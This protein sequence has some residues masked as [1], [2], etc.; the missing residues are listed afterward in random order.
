MLR[1]FILF[2]YG[3]RVSMKRAGRERLSG[4]GIY[5][6]LSAF[7]EALFRS[8]RAIQPTC[9]HPDSLSQ[10]ALALRRATPWRFWGS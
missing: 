8:G 1:P 5:S 9:L 6:W 2:G 10:R 4:Y 7:L 3:D